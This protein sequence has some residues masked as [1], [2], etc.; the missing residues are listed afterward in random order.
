MKVRDV[1]ERDLIKLLLRVINKRKENLMVYD[2]VVAYPISET[3]AIVVKTDSFIESTDLL[4]NMKP[5]QVGRKLVVMN[6]SDFAAKGVM[7]LG[8]LISLAL[9]SDYDVNY[10][11]RVYEGAEETALEYGFD[12][13]GGDTSHGK[14][15]ML[16]GFL[17]GFQRKSKIV[18][19]DGARVGDYVAT[20]GVFGDTSVAFSI[21]FK[22]LEAP[23]EGL[24]R[25]V[26]KSV[27]EPKARL[28][29]GLKLAENA[30]IT[31]SIDSSDGLAISLY[32]LA[33]SSNVGILVE[34]IPLS[35]NLI[36]FCEY[37]GLDPIK[38][39]LYEGGEEFELI[40][41]I[42]PRSWHEAKEIIRG[43]GGELHYLGKVVKGKGVH[44]KV[45]ER[46]VLVEKRG[47]EHF[48]GWV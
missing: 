9:P 46:K 43:I 18:R 28:K 36:D 25:R 48:R 31:S 7:P 4:P 8:M 29:E 5:E 17:F 15:L 34:S 40:V 14:E 44:L 6:V 1:G 37:H 20:T 24:R 45:N 27:Y 35:Q 13:M 30:F 21:L 2:D 42:P 23:D 22:G 47:W 10:I 41:T 12:I 32:E 19:R 38:L 39:A 11:V 26:L 16:S 33:E 3:E